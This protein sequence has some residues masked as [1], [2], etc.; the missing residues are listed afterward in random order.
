MFCVKGDRDGRNKKH[1]APARGSAGCTPSTI[2]PKIPTRFEGLHN[3][4]LNG[5]SFAVRS[6][7]SKTEYQHRDA[8]GSIVYVSKQ[9]SG[10]GRAIVY[11]AFGVPIRGLSL[12]TED[13]TSS[14]G[15]DWWSPYS[16]AGTAGSTQ[17][18]QRYGY[19]GKMLDTA[20]GMYDYGF[21]HYAAQIGRF[22]TVDPIKDGLNWYAYVG[23]DPYESR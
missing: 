8:L 21:R 7:S 6:Q 14:Q 23:N 5:G 19:N 18:S 1:P 10:S 2:I 3:Q 12:S 11:D 17:S 16:A 9:Q 20:T 15:S 4:W 13:A 22:T